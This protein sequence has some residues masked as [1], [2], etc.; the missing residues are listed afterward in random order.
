MDEDNTLEVALF[1]SDIDVGDELSFDVVDIDNATVSVVGNILIIDSNDNYNGTLTVTVSIS[2]DAEE[3]LSDS[4]S[5]D[6]L[7]NAVNDAPELTFIEDEIIDEDTSL[8]LTLSASDIDGDDLTYSISEGE[9]ISRVINDLTGEISFTAALHFNG[10]EVFTVSVTDGEYTASQILNVSVT[11]VNDAPV[12]TEIDDATM[13]EGG[14]K[15]IIISAS[16]VDGDDLDYSITSGDNISA[17][18]EGNTITFT[19]IPDYFGE[20]SFTVSVSDEEFTV[21][22]DPFVLDTLAR[23]GASLTLVTSKTNGSDV[24][25]NSSS[26]TETVNDSSPK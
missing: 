2:D 24:T 17:V 13:D 4:T 25:V 18:L 11:P 10:S 1:G 16:D 14:T 19:T 9:N 22:S 8:S 23:V 12:L 20:E 3:P 7:V 26:D 6:V 5:F 15:V 21:T